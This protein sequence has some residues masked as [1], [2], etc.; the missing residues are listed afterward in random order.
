MSQNAAGAHG[1]FLFDGFRFDRDGGELFR[2]DQA[3]TDA[4][5]TIGSRARALLGLLVERQGKQWVAYI[6][7]D[8]GSG[9]AP[10][11][12]FTGYSVNGSF[13]E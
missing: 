8:R 3:G 10:V 1:A 12:L 6:I 7:D 5:V 11:R 2:V 9:G 4:P 13:A